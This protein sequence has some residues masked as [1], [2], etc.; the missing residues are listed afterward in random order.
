MKR[1]K[2]GNPAGGGRDVLLEMRGVTKRFGPVVAND[3]VDFD[4][5][6]GEVHALL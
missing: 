5:D 3:A 1:V 2:S 4:V 6:R